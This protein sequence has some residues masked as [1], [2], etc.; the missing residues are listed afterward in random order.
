M[1]VK[2]YRAYDLRQALADA[3]LDLGPNAAVLSQRQLR[4]SLWWPFSRPMWEVIASEGEAAKAE[5]HEPDERTLQLESEIA[6]IKGSRTDWCA[7][8]IWIGSAGPRK[9]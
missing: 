7:P 6:D 9:R 4:S 5:T 8:S 2:I 1:A 3:R